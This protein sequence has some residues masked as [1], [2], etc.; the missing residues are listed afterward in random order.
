MHTICSIISYIIYSKYNKYFYSLSKN[1]RVL[2]EWKQWTYCKG[3]LAANESTWNKLNVI[4]S[5]K[6]DHKLLPFLFCCRG[7]INGYNKVEDLLYLFD[8]FTPDEK[9]DIKI[10]RSYINTFYSIIIKYVN[11]YDILDELLLNLPRIKPE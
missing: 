3:L 1:S 4:L 7:I 11:L 8:Q 6:P 10:I 2:S 5:R 9:Q